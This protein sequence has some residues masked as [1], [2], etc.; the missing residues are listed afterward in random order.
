MLSRNLFRI[1]LSSSPIDKNQIEKTKKKIAA[2][3]QVLNKDVSYLFSHG[4]V[5]NEAYLPDSQ[6]I[7]IL[8]KTGEVIDLAS[9]S[10]L[11][12]IKAMSKTV[13]KNFLCWPK[14]VDL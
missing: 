9:A 1:Q 3:Y 4:T 10:D 14:N 12:Q 13:K 11:P 7:Q 5:T 8:M 2:T 6:S